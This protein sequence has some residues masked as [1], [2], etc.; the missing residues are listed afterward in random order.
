MFKPPNSDTLT[1]LL[2]QVSRR[3]RWQVH[4]RL[5]ELKIPCWCPADGSL[6]VEIN[7]SIEAV[8]VR[9]TVLQ[10]IASRAE[11]VDWLQRCWQV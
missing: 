11:L 10:F 4:R 1:G 6:R 3:D 5:Q 8:L 9:S 2:V 7:N